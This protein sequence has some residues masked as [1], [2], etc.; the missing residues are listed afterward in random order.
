MAER[1]CGDGCKGCI[2][3]VKMGGNGINHCNYCYSTGKPRGCPAGEGCIRYTPTTRSKR[4]RK[5]LAE[6]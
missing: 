6:F 3:Y 1:K 2:Y 5:Y 4:L